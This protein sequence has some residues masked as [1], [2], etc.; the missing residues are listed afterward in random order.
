MISFQIYQRPT[1]P[2]SLYKKL[3]N[4]TES[5]N[6]TSEQQQVQKTF[7]EKYGAVVEHVVSDA[8]KVNFTKINL[9]DYDN[10]FKDDYFMCIEAVKS[11]AFNLMLCSSNMKDNF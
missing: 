10:T 2:L 1:P 6:L 8:E 3:Q 11:Y 4:T 9:K 5:N 7:A